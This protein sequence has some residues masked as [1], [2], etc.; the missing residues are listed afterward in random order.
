MRRVKVLA[1]VLA[2]LSLAMPYAVNAQLWSGMSVTIP[3][4]FYVGTY[5]FP[6]GTYS[7]LRGANSLVRLSNHNGSNIGIL[8]V[9]TPNTTKN[10]D[11]SLVF[12]RYESRYFLSEVR[13]QDHSMAGA[14]PKSKF[15]TDIARQFAAN[16]ALVASNKS[17]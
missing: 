10:R 5:K 13:W 3:F 2:F 9:D 1:A 14:V 17:R 7:V 4:E 16:Q 15:E 11:G 12:N 6:A 8:T